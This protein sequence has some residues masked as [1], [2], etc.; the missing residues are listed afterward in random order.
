[1]CELVVLANLF[2][3]CNQLTALSTAVGALTNMRWSESS[4][5]SREENLSGPRL[6]AKVDAEEAEL[7]FF[8]D[9]DDG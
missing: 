9:A 8:E 2:L 3:R 7:R 1:M 5:F 6:W 4:L